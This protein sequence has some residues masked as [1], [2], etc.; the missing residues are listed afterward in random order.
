MAL[1]AVKSFELIK[2]LAHGPQVTKTCNA[3]ETHVIIR[4]SAVIKTWGDVRR[5]N[6][7]VC[8]R[9]ST[10]IRRVLRVGIKRNSVCFAAYYWQVDFSACI[11][12]SKPVKQVLNTI[13]HCLI[14]SVSM[15][16][17]VRIDPPHPLVYRKEATKW[18]GPSDETGKTEVRVTAGVAR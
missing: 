8:H 10:I 17:R 13:V 18:G 2:R 5:E 4:V 15:R 14:T 16:I 1:D 11:A 6:L 9:Q 7:A 3:R 12:L